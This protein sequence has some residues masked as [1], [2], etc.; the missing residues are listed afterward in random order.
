MLEEYEGSRAEFMK[1]LAEQDALPAYI[2]RANRVAQIWDDLLE[3]CG[4]T[5]DEMLD[6][7][8][9]RLG[10]LSAILNA[11]W[12]SISNEF[13]QPDSANQ[14]KRLAE[15]WNPQLRMDLPS[16][17]SPRKRRAAIEDLVYSFERFNRRWQDHVEGIGLNEINFQR[18]QYNDYFLVEKAAALGSDKLA[19]MGFE[20]LPE[21]RKSDIFRKFPLLFVPLPND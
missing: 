8:R 16:S 3:T 19:E 21:C 14:L 1:M 2:V 15:D 9:M 17:T 4:Q 18:Q 6:M 7:P 20:R 11:D 5:Y 12:H 13:Q 10:Q